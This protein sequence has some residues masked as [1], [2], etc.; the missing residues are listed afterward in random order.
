MSKSL[1]D[2]PSNS[3][4]ITRA[5]NG[6]IVTMPQTR[7]FYPLIQMGMQ[8]QKEVNPENDVDAIIQKSKEVERPPIP[9]CEDFHVFKDYRGVIAFLAELEDKL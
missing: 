8:I 9:V 7:P 6:F 4:E 3:I 2:A 5:S 1:I